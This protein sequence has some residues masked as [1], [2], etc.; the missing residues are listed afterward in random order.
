MP[1][2]TWSDWSG[3]VGLCFLPRPPKFPGVAMEYGSNMESC[4]GPYPRSMR[5]LPP[6][7]ADICRGVDAGQ[8]GLSLPGTK[9]Q[10]GPRVGVGVGGAQQTPPPQIHTHTHNA[11]Y[12]GRGTGVWTM[13]ACAGVC[14]P[15]DST[16]S[17]LSSLIGHALLAAHRARR[18]GDKLRHVVC[19]GWPRRCRVIFS[20]V[21]LVV[22]SCTSFA[23]WSDVNLSQI[24]QAAA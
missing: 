22:A 14:D 1:R 8:P 10:K 13:E 5:L 6:T 16:S 2:K 15:C 21:C 7:A 24:H 11:V 20:P 12:Q 17:G 4:L 9:R 23:V 18:A 19:V 3:P